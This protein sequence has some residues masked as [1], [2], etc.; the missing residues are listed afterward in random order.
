MADETLLVAL[1]GGLHLLGL[2][3]GALL[4]LPLMRDERIVR[5]AHPGEEEDDGDGGND[6]LGPAPPRGP[7]PGGIPLPDA[8]PARVR[9]REDARLADLL[10][11]RERRREHA[12][13]PSR[14]PAGR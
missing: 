9:L 13:L 5:S 7:R 1:L 2:G 14:T 8:V 11:G 4:L 6:R 10:P 12:P 3:F